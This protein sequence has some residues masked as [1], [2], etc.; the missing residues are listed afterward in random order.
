MAGLQIDIVTP[1]KL[2]FSGSAS[3]IR[4][5]G[6]FG[7]MG[8]L[9]G[10]DTVLSLLRGGMALVYVEGGEKQFVIGRGFAEI[11]PERVTVLTDLCEMTSSIDP[12]KASV[13]YATLEATMGGLNG[14]DA[15]TEGTEAALEVARARLRDASN[16]G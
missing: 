7:E 2:A 11:G 6:W 10:H 15:S 9:P 5:P 14:F 1:T 4:L 12:A 13:D 16:R 3:E 8:V